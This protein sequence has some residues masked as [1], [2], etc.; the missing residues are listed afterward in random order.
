MYGYELE[1]ILGALLARFVHMFLAGL[2]GVGRG[3]FAM[4][5]DVCVFTICYVGF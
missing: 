1:S 2:G 3:G 4:L 5:V